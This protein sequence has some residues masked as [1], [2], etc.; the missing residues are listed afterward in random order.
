MSHS[1]KEVNFASTITCPKCGKRSIVSYEE[2]MYACLNCDFERNLSSEQM[3]RKSGAG[4][5]IFALAGAL[6][7]FALIL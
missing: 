3:G 4:E 5:F 1:P 2:G 6:I 7:A